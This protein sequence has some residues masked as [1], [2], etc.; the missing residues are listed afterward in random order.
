MNKPSQQTIYKISVPV[1]LL[2]IVLLF[3]FLVV[4]MRSDILTINEDTVDARIELEKQYLNGQLL[5]KTQNQF[6]S[7]KPRLP[8]MEAAILKKGQELFLITTLEELAIKHGL[9]QKL[10]MSDL[11]FSDDAEI[12]D[13]VPMSIRVD[14]TGNYDQVLGFLSETE[15][16]D[17]YINWDSVSIK[18]LASP[19]SGRQINTFPGLAPSGAPGS[20]DFD[21]SVRAVFSGETYWQIQ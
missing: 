14:L 20:G 13:V 1:L 3:L 16:L 7:V 10:S 6:E 18:S 19:E 9:I 12:T 15:Q 8:Q 4:P 2:I 21:A 11:N 5:R 17:F